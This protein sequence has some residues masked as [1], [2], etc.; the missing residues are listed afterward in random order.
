MQSGRAPHLKRRVVAT[1]VVLAL[2]GGGFA[3]AT[4]GTGSSRRAPARAQGGELS[5]SGVAAAPAGP[6]RA[7]FAVG[8]RVLRLVDHSRHIGLPSGASS[9]RRLVTYVRYPAVG[10]ASAKELRNAPPQRAAEPFPL[11]VFGH[12]FTLTPAPYS[13]LL[14]A[15]ARA[16]YVVAAPR[17]PLENAKAPG[18]PDESDLINQPADMSFVIS[19]LLSASSRSGGQLQGLIDPQRIAVSGHSD[20]GETALAVAYDRRFRDPRVGAAAIFSGARIPGT[21]FSFPPG[22]PP[23]LATQGT[24]DTINP[25]RFTRSFYDAASPPKFLLTLFGASHLPPYTN[26]RPQ[27][28]IVER[29]TIAF[30]DRY[31]KRE[32]GPV[33][34]LAR[35]GTVRGIASLAAQP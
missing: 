10:P 11:V 1:A 15:W 31:L 2:L 24:A 5:Q 19:N 9:P 35:L 14:E 27:L 4:L 28:H 23:L 16:G 29:V 13:R 21:G 18:G 33:S 8:V 3:I 7:P 26:Q 34:R 22:S 6:P 12:G 32:A 17:F 25:P 20:G 30:F